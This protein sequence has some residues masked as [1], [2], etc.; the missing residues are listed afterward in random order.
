M[1]SGLEASAVRA[2]LTAQHVGTNPSTGA[3]GSNPRRSTR[4]SPI[5]GVPRPPVLHAGRPRGVQTFRERRACRPRSLQPLLE[6]HA[7]RPRSVQTPIDLVKTK[8]RGVETAAMPR[9]A[10]FS[11][12]STPERPRFVSPP[13][14]SG[15]LRTTMRLRRGGVGPLWLAR[16]ARLPELVEDRQDVGFDRVGVVHD[17]TAPTSPLCKARFAQRDCSP[18]ATTRSRTATRCSSLPREDDTEART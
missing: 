13:R 3:R 8:I 11:G 4:A 14:G 18:M 7:C 9:F 2:T 16:G 17:V 12:G 10:S 5:G 15:P 1:H 6:P